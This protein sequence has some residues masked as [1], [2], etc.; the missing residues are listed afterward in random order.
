[1]QKRETRP[2][3]YKGYAV[4]A[5]ENDCGLDMGLKFRKGTQ[6]H[7]TIIDEDG[8]PISGLSASIKGKIASGQH[9]GEILIAIDQ[10]LNPRIAVPCNRIVSLSGGQ[11][12]KN[13]QFEEK[14][15]RVHRI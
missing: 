2:T 1:M 6:P 10:G 15:V 11:L 7:F 4:L 3:E 8:K 14:P 12:P 13:L 5:Y 9:T